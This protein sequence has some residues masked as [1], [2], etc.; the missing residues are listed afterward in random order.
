MSTSAQPYY[1]AVRR[2][3]EAALCID[4]FNSQLVERHSAPEVEVRATRE[5]LGNPV[6]IARNAQEKVLIEPSANAVR[7]SIAV[8]KADDVERI[9]SSKFMSFMKQRAENF[10]ILRKKP[11]AGYDVSFLITQEHVE[12]MYTKKL[13]DFIIHF[14]QEF[15][16]EISEMKLSVN[17]RARVSA[18]DFLKRFN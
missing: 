15:D 13:V 11:I 1:L 12:S 10:Y 4:T 17:A 2:T 18:E 16:K 8:K 3:L 5:A 14:M 7:L 9:L 6:I